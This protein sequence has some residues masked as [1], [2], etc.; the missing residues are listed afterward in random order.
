LNIDIIYTFT[1]FRDR[2]YRSFIVL[3]FAPWDQRENSIMEARR[4]LIP[5]VSG[6]HGRARLSGHAVRSGPARF[7]IAV[8][9]RGRRAGL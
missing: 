6:H 1:G 5:L 4:T 2:P 7:I 3:R 9:R 8:A